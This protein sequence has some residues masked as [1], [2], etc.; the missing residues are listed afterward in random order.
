MKCN[1]F[2]QFLHFQIC[3]HCF[4]LRSSKI[5]FR[6]LIRIQNRVGEFII[7]RHITQFLNFN[8]FV[9][10]HVTDY[11]FFNQVIWSHWSQCIFL[12]VTT[13]WIELIIRDITEYENKCEQVQIDVFTNLNRCSFKGNTFYVLYMSIFLATESGILQNSWK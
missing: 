13:V 12:S 1:I 4:N 7:Q 5:D 3:I 8:I 10:I 11:P 6:L 9:N 2:E